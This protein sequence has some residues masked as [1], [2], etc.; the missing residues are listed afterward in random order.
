MRYAYKHLGRQREGCTA[1]VRWGGS[2]AT[3]MLFDPVNFTKYVDRLPCHC[4]AGGRYHCP[5]A[6]LPIPS[7]G[8]WYAVVDLGGHTSGR[9][10]TVEIQPPESA[11]SEATDQQ[12]DRSRVAP[13]A[14][15]TPLHSVAA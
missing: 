12:A 7:D 5:P 9:R 13:G 4:D 11:R 2:A 8:D 10:P 14:A 6:Q 3:V 1:V 15:A